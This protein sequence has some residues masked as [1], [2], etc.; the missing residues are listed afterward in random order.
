MGLA[1]QGTL[2]GSE[3]LSEKLVP[4]FQLVVAELFAAPKAT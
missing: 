1:L 3:V 2:T 4:K